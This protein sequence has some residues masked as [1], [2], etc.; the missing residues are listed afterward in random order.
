MYLYGKEV[1]RLC[2]REALQG[3]RLGGGGGG[4]GGLGKRVV[5]NSV[6]VL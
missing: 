6:R 1:E 5:R 4:T 2:D 3:R